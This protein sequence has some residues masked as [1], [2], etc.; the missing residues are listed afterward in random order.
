MVNRVIHYLGRDPHTLH[1][2]DMNTSGVVL[3]AKHPSVVPHIHKQFRE[4][5]VTKLYLAVALGIPQQP[6]FTV[7]APLGPDER[8][9]CGSCR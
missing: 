2:L 7:D 8:E 4:K 5:T 6:S 9:K 3:L 1:R